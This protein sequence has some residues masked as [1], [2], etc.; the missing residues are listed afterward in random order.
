MKN[1]PQ[2]YPPQRPGHPPDDDGRAAGRLIVVPVLDDVLATLGREPLLIHEYDTGMT[3]VTV[4][5][6]Q[7]EFELGGAAG[8]R[9]AVLVDGIVSVDRG[10]RSSY[11]TRRAQ[12]EFTFD[13]GRPYGK[14]TVPLL[15]NTL[16]RIRFLPAAKEATPVEYFLSTRVHGCFID[17]VFQFVADKEV[18]EAEL[19]AELR[20]MIELAR[21]VSRELGEMLESNVELADVDGPKTGKIDPDG[22]DTLEN[23]RIRLSRAEWTRA[24]LAVKCTTDA[25]EQAR[26]REEFLRQAVSQLLHEATHRKGFLDG[27]TDDLTSVNREERRTTGDLINRLIDLLERLRTHIPG[28]PG[29]DAPQP[30]GDGGGLDDEDATE[31]FDR[32]RVIVHRQIRYRWEKGKPTPV[33]SKWRRVVRKWEKFV[34]RLREIREGPGTDDEKREQAR[35][36]FEDF[37]RDT[38]ERRRDVE[39]AM[40]MDWRLDWDRDTLQPIDELTPRDSFGGRPIPDRIY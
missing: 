10:E 24:L 17:P 40:D 14:V 15:P 6:C 7:V 18:T 25:D 20:R 22:P 23:T 4:A 16:N 37:E 34:E 2:G 28:E 39:D 3:P 36:E 32:I 1:P 5:S 19:Q 9:G 29:S 35:E 30:L 38:A 33:R 26:R 31:W 21:K 12:I 27:E 8:A 11:Q 13:D